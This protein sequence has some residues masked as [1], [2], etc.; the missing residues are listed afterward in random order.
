MSNRSFGQQVLLNRGH[1]VRSIKFKILRH[2]CFVCRDVSRS[3]TIFYNVVVAMPSPDHTLRVSSCVDII[4]TTSLYIVKI[5]ADYKVIP[6][7]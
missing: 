5:W 7:L 1:R 2:A 4:Y 6:L 3:Q